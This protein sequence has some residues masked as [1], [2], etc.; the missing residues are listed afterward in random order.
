MVRV[1]VRAYLLDQWIE[2]GWRLAFRTPANTVLNRLRA[3]TATRI[4]FLTRR[5]HEVG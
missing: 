5:V 4:T 3:A 2:F 1:R